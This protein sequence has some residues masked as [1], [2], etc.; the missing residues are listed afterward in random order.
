MAC[1]AQL[2]NVIAPIM[3][4]NGGPAWVQPIF[5]PFMHASNFGRGTVFSPVVNCDTYDSNKIKNVPYVETVAV[6]NEEKSELTVFAVNRSLE[7]S[8]DLS[9]ELRQVPNASVLEH[10]VLE[11]ED[12]KA[13]NS[14]KD[15]DHVAPHY[16]GV[17]EIKSEEAVA[18]L[19]SNPG[20]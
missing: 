6:L 19:P 18:V 8:I 4:E 14:A 7:E 1:L 13:V 11:H 16:N 2:V 5:Y 9:I 20:M 10:I 15:P 12:L 17:T 3:T